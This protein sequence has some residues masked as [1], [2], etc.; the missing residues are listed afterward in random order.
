MEIFEYG[1][2]MWALALA[3]DVR[4]L[5][6]WCSVYALVLLFYS[7]VYQIRISRWPNIHGEVLQSGVKRFGGTESNRA[8]QSYSTSARYRYT[9]DG[10]EHTGE[11]V[12]P[13]VIVASHNV[14]AVLEKQ[15]A[16]IET[17][18]QNR[19]RVFFNPRAPH[20]SFLIRPGWLGISVTLSLAVL[21]AVLYWLKYHR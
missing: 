14:R 3:G 18:K 11:R 15:M 10:D 4:G 1:R 19:V 17:D 20:K 16:S 21:P 6:F 13:W 7:A 8:E 5:F 9:V 2:E 12:S